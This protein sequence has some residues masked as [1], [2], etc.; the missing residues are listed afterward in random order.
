MGRHSR[1]AGSEFTRAQGADDLG[2][3][4]VRTVIFLIHHYEL[5]IIRLAKANAG[6]TTD[7]SK[8]PCCIVICVLS[9]LS[10]PF[11]P[12]HFDRNDSSVDFD[13]RILALY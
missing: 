3:A 1:K 4:T 11:L 7:T 6:R 5:I 8:I 13:D 2:C 9:C 10:F 12:T